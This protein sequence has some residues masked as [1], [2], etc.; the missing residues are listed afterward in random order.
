M[1]NKPKS[2]KALKSGR[3]PPEMPASEWSQAFDYQSGATYW[4]NNITGAFSWSPPAGM[5]SAARPNG[6]N[7]SFRAPPPPLPSTNKGGMMQP[8]PPLSR[9]PVAA[10]LAAG[11][12][13]A[14][15]GGFGS[16]PG[17]GYGN[18]VQTQGPAWEEIYDSGTD[19]SYWVNPATGQ[20][21]WQNPVG[22]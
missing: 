9:M 19:A 21:S 20:F 1:G 16:A 5:Q 22:P 13:G 2:K 3:Y 17:V 12:F 7:A 18:A 14:A 10:P 8:A 6:N 11:A 4:I 15:P